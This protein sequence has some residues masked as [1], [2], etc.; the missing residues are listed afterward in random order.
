MYILCNN[1]MTTKSGRACNR[2]AVTVGKR[3]KAGLL[4]QEND[5]AIGAD[6]DE[7]NQRLESFRSSGC[8]EKRPG[9]HGGC[10]YRA[11]NNYHD[12]DYKDEDWKQHRHLDFRHRFTGYDGDDDEDEDN[13]KGHLIVELTHHAQEVRRARKREAKEMRQS[14]RHGQ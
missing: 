1:N 11:R 9:E 14:A 7:E 6:V 4:S 5:D 12:N 13:Y 3:K 2:G 8:F 10:V